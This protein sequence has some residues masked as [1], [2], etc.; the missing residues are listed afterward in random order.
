M[1][2]IYLFTG[3]LLVA[4]CLSLSPL[5]GQKI[6]YT[7]GQVLIKMKSDRSVSQ[8]NNLR[9]QMT[10]RTL[11]TFNKLD[12]ELWE[13]GTPGQKVDILQLIE[14]YRN[15][16]D[17]EFIEP[18]YIVSVGAT[19]PND[20]NFGLLWGLHNTGQSG[21]V[22]DADIDAPEAWDIATG[23][24]SVV[25]GV[26]DTG[27]DWAHEDL[28]DNIWHN[29]GEDADGDGTV[30]EWNGST[31]IFDPG[32]E[33]GIDDDGNGYIDDFVGWDCQNNDN[34]PYDGH[35]HGTHVAGT[36]GASG[37]NNTGVVGVTW[38]VQLAG[39]KFL[40]DDGGGS[41]SD[42]LEALNYAV[43]MDMPIS[44]NSWGGGGY[45]S[46]FYQAL[47][48]ADDNGH[49]FIAAAGNGGFDRIGD[50]NDNTSYYPSSYTNDN[51]ISVASITRSDVL[52]GFSNY[53]P[54]SVDLGAP[55]S[56]IYSSNPMNQYGYKG[57]TSMATPHVAGACALVW[58]NNPNK[59]H[60]EIKDA[61]LNSV[62]VTPALNGKCV[63]DGRLNLYNAM[64]YFSG[65]G[66]I[67]CRYE[68]SLVLVELYNTT[69]GN[70][71]WL[72]N[73]N[74]SQPI[75]TWYG[76][77]LNAQG[78]VSEINLA[79]VQLGGTLPS[80]IG[81]LEELTRLDL[82]TNQLNGTIPSTLG[83]L[84]NLTYL[85]LS[86]NSFTGTI[87]NSLGNL[88]NLG[89]LYLSI[90]N[91]TGNIP[92]ALSNLGNLQQLFLHNNLLT[93]DIPSGFSSLDNLSHLYL[94]N[95]QLSGCYDPGLVGLCGQL[96]NS[97]RVSNGNNFDALWD[98]FCNNG[99]GS[100]GNFSCRYL[101]SLA[102][103]ALYN[104]AGGANWNTPWNLNQPINTW[105]G[106]TLNSDGCV[107]ELSLSNQNLIGTIPSDLGN[108]ASLTR[109][110]LPSNSLSGTIPSSLGN[111]SNLTSLYLSQN[112]LTGSIPASLG[113][114]S[115]LDRMNLQGNNLTG[116][117]PDELGNL[118]NITLLYLSM[119]SLTGEIP[120][121]FSNLSS[122]E[123]LSLQVNQLTGSIPAGFGNLNNLTRMIINYNDLSGCYDAN[124]SNLCNQLDANYNT[125]SYISG[126]NNFDADWEDF[127][128][129]NT[130]L[131]VEI[132]C[133]YT[134]SLA[135]VAL[136]NSAGGA[137]WSNPWNLNQPIDTWPGIT[138]NSDDCVRE[139]SLSYKNL[140]GT[141]PS[142]LGNLSSMTRLNVQ[143]NSLSGSIPAS[144][145]NL[146]NLTSLYLAQN[147]LTG[148][149][150]ASIGN[151]S[152]LER[153]NLQS[154]DLSGSIPDELGNLTNITLLYLSM[155]E[156][157][158][159]IPTTFSNLSNLENLSLQVNQLTGPIPPG[160]GSLGNLSKMI[161]NYNDL[162]G[163][164]DENLANLCNQLD[165]N[166]N[167]SGYISGLN[168]FDAPW[169]DFCNVGAGSCTDISCRYTDSLA[170]VALYNSAG[171][172][173]WS[174]PWNLNQPI[175]TWYG[176]TL[177]S[178]DCV[179][180]ISLSYKN[181]VGTL[182]SELGNLSSMTRLNL[183]GNSLS[184]SIPAS[185]GNLSNL[186]SLYLAQ[187]DLTGT[188]PA[189]IG[190]LSNLERMNL[191][192]NELSGSIPEELGNLSSITLLYLSMNSLT[193]EIPTTFSNLS[194]LENLSLQVNQLTGS[195][196]PGFGSL[197]NLSKMI[198]NYNDLSGCYDEN[199]ANLCNQLDA[200]YNTNS[201]ISGSNNFDVDW[202]DFCNGA[203]AC[204]TEIWPGDFNNDGI[205]DNTDILY[206]GQ[207]EGSSGLSRPNADNN[208]IGQISPNWTT[209]VNGINSKYQDANGNGTI[210]IQDL[211][212]LIDNYSSIHN[213]GTTINSTNTMK[214]SLETIAAY[215]DATN[216][217][218]EYA[219]YAQNSDGTPAQVSGAACDIVFN[220]F[221][222]ISISMNTNNSSL[223]PDEYIEVY[224]GGNQIEVGLTRT[225]Q[226]D[227]LCSDP[228]AIITAIVATEDLPN[229]EAYGI[230][231]MQGSTMK[232]N[233]TIQSASVTTLYD[234]YSE[235]SP[236]NNNMLL[237]AEVAHVQ[238][239]S[240]G[241]ISL[242][243]A[244]GTAAYDILWNTGETTSQIS[245]LTP[246][247]YTVTVNDANGLSSTMDIEIEGQYI[248]LYDE[249]GM[250]IPCIELPCPTVLDFVNNMPDAIHQANSAIHT[251]AT[252]D[253][254]ENPQLKAGNVISLQPGFTVPPSS[255]VRVEI[256][257]CSGN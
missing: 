164:Y 22:V 75:D 186:T 152:N 255:S 32:D 78:C 206:W 120:T 256:E 251:N 170:L 73:W 71:T 195:I 197:S 12:I 212:V 204:P 165:P 243:I 52:S 184:G 140:V 30:L 8:K 220:D 132:T 86:A 163:C 6:N 241:S 48:A 160:L 188:I 181:L 118:T 105:N 128:A 33:N 242:Q 44:N 239:L 199:L 245:D 180:E 18:N 24:P 177:N 13:V 53:G 193:G 151:L 131:C 63:S 159:E 67:G 172:A 115:N 244:G 34:N 178:D 235:V 174:N 1:K 228:I 126:G 88:N 246:G 161:L 47:E 25:V 26:I 40:R 69:G 21:G 248:P 153:M 219:L 49:L 145:G 119:N 102:L 125:N 169:E 81:N 216:T 103:V 146:S 209:D 221:T 41:I 182:P 28:V 124:L 27:I 104:S 215:S 121:T 171:G 29:L 198:L 38:D 92:D 50:N 54:N 156:L 137:N 106:V 192:G 76:I 109:L 23:S 46:A 15:H 203:G 253:N 4:L 211:Q 113:N 96:Q 257:D 230:S 225:D 196:P 84:S 154:N 133:R 252:L 227:Q 101:D 143:G 62:E 114:L 208:W 56:S 149:I 229:G 66:P 167:T 157:T 138:L 223:Q 45:S 233:G 201:Y 7:P 110:S 42:A 111:L 144:L 85:S 123:N 189:S 37:N 95:N 74:L 191:Q 117:I 234:I 150:P 155:N 213:T 17:I 35:S 99:T 64:T 249:F 141:I 58:G 79:G 77:T 2:T 135:L 210:D 200:N 238:C 31:W 134:D 10:G 98:D 51:V 185:L 68:D 240:A 130:G 43:A 60:A 254:G 187:N 231:I 59:T 3:S 217:T 116:S 65:P 14:Q 72:Y 147:D 207:A 190:N 214:F 166:Y 232:G 94:D 250:L 20:P 142:E 83:N 57:G 162:S 168:N 80:S 9:S 129:S 127:C 136:Y 89:Y 247:V 97:Y 236:D 16:P 218:L 194:N 175:D 224:G 237:T 93:G 55:G 70:T 179:R 36:I 139:I 202:E 19:F 173:N 158:G 11:E 91:L 39:L 226:T 5:Q 183:Q 61:I 205:A 82:F 90:N 222:P 107:R 176:V 112:D 148:T 122:L 87:P 100:C 108:L